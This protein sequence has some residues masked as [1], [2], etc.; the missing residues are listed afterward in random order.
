MRRISNEVLEKMEK[1]IDTVVEIYEEANGYPDDSKEV[2]CPGCGKMTTNYSCA[3]GI[4]KH[5][6][7]YCPQCNFSMMQ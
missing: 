6:H 2:E 7:F 1:L 5:V 4:N 3:W